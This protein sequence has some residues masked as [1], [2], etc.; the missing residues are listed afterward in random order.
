MPKPPVTEYRIAAAII[1]FIT[2]GDKMNDFKMAT[3][4]KQILKLTTSM[5]KIPELQSG[6]SMIEMLGVLA[7]IGVLSI[8]GVATFQYAM[9][10]DKANKVI[11]D[12]NLLREQTLTNAADV[13][14]ENFEPE[15]GYQMSSQYGEGGIVS[16][17]IN[18]LDKDVCERLLSMRFEDLRFLHAEQN[19]DILNCGEDITFRAVFGLGDNAIIDE[20]ACVIPCDSNHECH[21]RRCCP[22]LVDGICSATASGCPTQVAENGTPCEHL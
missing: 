6:R 4:R 20:D 3:N 12:I 10:K 19:T 15:S 9:T 21:E 2:K 8:G 14:A 17:L 11:Y 5:T 18:D 1:F 22:K 16:I 7:I 13:P